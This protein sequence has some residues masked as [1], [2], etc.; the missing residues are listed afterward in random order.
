MFV[1]Y[2]TFKGSP[3]SCLIYPRVSSSSCPIYPRACQVLIIYIQGFGKFLSYMSK[4]ST[5]LGLYIQGLPQPDDLFS[6]GVILLPVDSTAKDDALQNLALD[7]DL[8]NQLL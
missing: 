6:Q 1:L 8:I 2:Y 7:D 5:I 4:G 3:C